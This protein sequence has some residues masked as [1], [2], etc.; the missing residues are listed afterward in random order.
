MAFTKTELKLGSGSLPCY[1]GGTG[2]PVLFFHS[3][4]GVR[5]SPALDTLSQSFKFYIPILPG[6]DGTPRRENIRTMSD[7]ADL[8]AEIIDTEIKRPCDVMGHSFG[9]WAAAWLGARHSDKV[10]L[11]V[12]CAAAGFRPEGVGGLPDDPAALRRGMYAHP[13]KLPAESD[14][15]SRGAANRAAAKQY[16]GG[17]ATDRDLVGALDKITA[18]TLIL[19]GTKDGI[20]PVESARLLKSKIPHAFSVYLYDAAHA[21]DVDQP[22][23]FADIV[24][25]FLKR[26]EAFIV[27]RTSDA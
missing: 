1:V 8:G 26:G 6:F 7:L 19:Q 12:L 13:E 22:E 17:T 4:G 15:P 23:R 16:N 5:L 10:S 9:G 18:L 14:D 20:I 11:M 3:A 25:D 21:L 27:N 2:E 24:G